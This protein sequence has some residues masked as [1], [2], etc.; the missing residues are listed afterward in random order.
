MTVLY[1]A[2]CGVCAALARW[3]AC[4]GR[5]VAVAPIASATGARLLRDLAAADRLG[6][7]HAVDRLGRRHTGAAAIPVVL[8]ALPAAAP[9]ALLARA[10]PGLTAAAY[11]T[12]ARNR[13]RLST[14]LGLD[15]CTVPERS[16]A[17]ADGPR[18]TVPR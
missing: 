7:M 18:P 3:V 2:D 17:S 13:R 14:A 5:D 16:E 6:G 8:A 1:D 10:V 12:L 15:A 9:V 11:A 4:R